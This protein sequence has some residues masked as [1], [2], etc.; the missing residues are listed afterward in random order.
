MYS[1]LILAEEPTETQITESI[2]AKVTPFLKDKE[3]LH[4]M[5]SL[6]LQV[7]LIEFD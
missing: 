4:H 7:N 6:S 3:F 5:A 1:L 2:I